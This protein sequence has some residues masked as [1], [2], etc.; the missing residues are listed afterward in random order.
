[1]T[2]AEARTPDALVRLVAGRR[3]R[4]PDPH[5]YRE[6]PQLRAALAGAPS[7]PADPLGAFLDHAVGPG[8]HA[9][10]P[11]APSTGAVAGVAA[12]AGTGPP[13]HPRMKALAGGA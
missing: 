12:A 1:M 6:L 5:L 9:H 4:H 11:V 10:H 2:A 8:D 3:P 7:E 13:A